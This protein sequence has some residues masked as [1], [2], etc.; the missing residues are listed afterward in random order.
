VAER[1]SPGPN[2]VFYV[3]EIDTDNGTLTQVGAPVSVTA[4]RAFGFATSPDGDI[5]F[6]SGNDDEVDAFTIDQGDGTLTPLPP[7]F[8][9]QDAQLGE[10]VLDVVNEVFYV[11]GFTS[12]QV[13]AY[14]LDTSGRPST[15]IAGSPYPTP[16]TGT[17]CTLINSTGEFLL[18]TNVG[19]FPDEGTV[20]CFRILPDGSL[21]PVPGSP[22]PAG[23]GTFDLA[24][25]RLEQ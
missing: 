13:E 4:S 22:F 5:L 3:F 11:C 8:A 18:T 6:V 17:L 20:S 23:V 24:N 2:G 25:V 14:R 15:A 7:T 10:M 9:A 16:T 12:G 1:V 21:S 19:V